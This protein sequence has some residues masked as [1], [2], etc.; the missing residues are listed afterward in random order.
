MAMQNELAPNTTE[1]HQ[2]RLAYLEDDFVPKAITGEIFAKAQENS[3]ALRVAE[4]IEVTYGETVIPVTTT[5]P[6]AGQ[7]GVGTANSQREGYRKPLSGVAWASKS[8]SPIKIAT[9]VTA[10]D[11]FARVNPQNRFNS[12]R[13]KMS[14]AIGRAIDLAVFHGIQPIDGNPYQGIDADNVL[15]NTTNSVTI[16]PTDDVVTKLL[17]GYDMVSTDFEFNGWATD[18]RYRSRLAAAMRSTDDDGNVLNP[19]QINLGA[20]SSELLGLRNEYGRAV[21]G[22]LGAADDSGVRVFGGDWSQ[23]KLGYAEQIRFKVSD[24]ATLTDG[25]NTVNLW[26]TNQIAILCEVTF[27]WIVGDLEAF[28]KF[29][30]SGS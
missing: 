3:L 14:R 17:E 22:D 25:T 21:G 28:V 9:I 5:E 6:E 13:D 1:R 12:L 27:G 30:P 2:G 11:E 26:Q 10:S 15:V 20:R 18:P 16:A 23:L 4:S 7:V 24:Q 19:G 8:F 29:A